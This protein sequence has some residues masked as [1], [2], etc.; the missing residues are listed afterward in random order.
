MKESMSNI[1]MSI[2]DAIMV[3]FVIISIF[4]FSIF[5]IFWG[6]IKTLIKRDDK[7]EDEVCSSDHGDQ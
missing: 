7:H 1:F 5:G 2:I 6:A 4:V 3:I